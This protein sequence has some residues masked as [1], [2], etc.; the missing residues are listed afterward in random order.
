[1]SNLL[2]QASINAPEGTISSARPVFF[3]DSFE[4]SDMGIYELLN[5]SSLRQKDDLQDRVA[6]R[7]LL[8]NFLS[9]DLTVVEPMAFSWDVNNQSFESTSLLFELYMSTLSLGEELLRTECNY[10]DAVAMFKHANEILQQWKTADLVFPSCPHVCTKEYLQNMISLCKSSLLLKE[11]RKGKNGGTALSSAT[12][13]YDSYHLGE[14]SDTALNHYLLAV[15][16]YTLP[17]RKRTRKR[18]SRETWRTNLHDGEG[19]LRCMP[20]GRPQQAS[21]ERII[22]QRLERCLS[23]A[24]EHMESLLRFSCR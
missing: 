14:W 5:L 15:R 1:M 23:E 3:E 24:P 22:G 2:P 16:S 10:K 6:Y 20:I 18:W 12:A 7:E 19:S 8:L 4:S 11:M 17:N 13:M 21:H 9:S